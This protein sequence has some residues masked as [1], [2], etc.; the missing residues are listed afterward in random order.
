MDGHHQEC[1]LAKNIKR[2]MDK[3]NSDIKIRHRLVYID[4]G[5]GWFESEDQK[6]T[7]DIPINFSEHDKEF[8]ITH[9]SENYWCFTI[10]HGYHFVS[11]NDNT[12]LILFMD[13]TDR[14]FE[15]QSGRI[16]NIIKKH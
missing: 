2:K 8:V 3:N 12:V 10:E 14:G 5:I 15:I 9:E 11:R 1:L 4:N 16:L 13:K 6:S 7:L